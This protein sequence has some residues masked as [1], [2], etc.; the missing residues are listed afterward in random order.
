MGIFKNMQARSLS[1]LEVLLQL[2]RW[3]VELIEAL[4]ER[5]D[6]HKAVVLD[7]HHAPDQRLQLA[8]NHNH[9]PTHSSCECLAPHLVWTIATYA[10][11]SLS[12]QTETLSDRKDLPR[13]IQ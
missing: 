10:A 1:C 3:Q 2:P 11:G 5:P 8:L 6:A 7:L 4:Q 9:L 12:A 13:W